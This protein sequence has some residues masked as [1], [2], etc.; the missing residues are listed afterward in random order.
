MRYSMRYIVLAVLSW[1]PLP[2]QAQVYKTV[3]ENGNVVYTDNPRA[4][5]GEQPKPV[6]LPAINTQPPPAVIP[7]TG[8]GTGDAEDESQLPTRYQLSVSSPTDGTFVPP[9]QRDLTVT[10]TLEPPLS[11]EHRLE[12]MLNGKTVAQ[13]AA[14]TITLKEITRGSHSLQ[15]RVVNR[16]GKV[17]GI[18]KP[19]TVHVRRATVAK[20]AGKGKK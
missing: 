20:P 9:G 10:A 15:V 7:R 17:L 12:V 1:L 8:A 3:D 2:G 19:V 6:K 13:E 5:E 16:Q 4:V 18:S 14:A 11:S